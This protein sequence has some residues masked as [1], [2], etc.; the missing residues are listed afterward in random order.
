[1]LRLLPPAA[2]VRA[3]IHEAL[4]RR[5]VS[6]M[7]PTVRARVSRVRFQCIERVARLTVEVNGG[8]RDRSLA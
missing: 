1:M 3:C 7:L 6:A 5:I 4:L 2:R 8:E